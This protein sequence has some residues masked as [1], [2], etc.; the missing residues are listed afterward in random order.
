MRH[1]Y[2]TTPW[3]KRL[4]RFFEILPGVLSWSILAGSVIFSF[5]VPVW[6]AVFII[7][8]DLYWLLKVSYLSVYLLSSYRRL[9]RNVKTDWLARA[10]DHP[11]FSRIRHLIIL[12]TYKES[13]EVILSALEA[14]A[15]SEYPL[16]HLFVVVAFEQR[17]GAD[18]HERA[19]AFEAAYGHVFGHFLMTFHPADIA[20]EIAGKGSN[21]AWAARQAVAQIETLGWSADDVIVSVFDAD[22]VV[23]PKYFAMLAERYL[24]HPTPHRVS[25]QPVPMFLNNL[26]DAPALMRVIAMSHTFWMMMEQGR[27]ERLITF[28]SHSMSLRALLDIGYWDT[29]VVSEDSRVFWQAFLRY[30]GQYACEPLLLPIYMDTVLADTYWQS[31]VNQYKQQRRWAYG[32]ENIPYVFLGFLGN[33]R[34]PLRKKIVQSFRLLEGFISWATY[35]II[36]FALGWL[37]LQLGG[38]A[39]NHT[40]LAVSLPAITRVLMTMSMVGM[41]VTATL[42]M[43]LLPSRPRHHGQHRFAGMLLQWILLPVATIFLGSLPAL[44]SQTRVIFRKYLG[45]WVTDKVRKSDIA[46]HRALS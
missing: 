5:L 24:T 19:K 37:P 45:F 41:L 43:F 6:V 38:D 26:W 42:S 22:T 9:R 16:E 2:A 44:D 4:A 36:I 11:N 30:N 12:P 15:R 20:G 35:A 14:I 33:K 1:P 7:V 13:A 34:I 3:Q 28:S 39:F 46:R 29:Y 23:H 18:I 40:H 27:P 10:I 25:Y 8:F 21:Q 32:I 31:I 17:E